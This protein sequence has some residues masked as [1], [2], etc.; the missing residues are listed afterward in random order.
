MSGTLPAPVVREVS[1]GSPDYRAT[2]DLRRQV[3]LEPFGIPLE[4]A[5]VDDPVA[6]HFG[7]FSTHDCV[8]CLLLLDRGEGTW[9]LR[10]MAVRADQQGQGVGRRLVEVA[11]TR[12]REAGGTRLMA[13]AREPAVPFY[14]RVGFSVEGAPFEQVGLPHR[15][16]THR[17]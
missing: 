17:F 3:L 14:L 4:A 6:F 12:A 2:V 11:L 16:V 1:L 9:Q 10:Q 7:A 15:L 8:G 13:H 5:Q